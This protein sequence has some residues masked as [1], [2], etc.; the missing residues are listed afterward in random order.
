[1]I[2][3]FLLRLLSIQ[4]AH[5]GD[6]IPYPGLLAYRVNG[7]EGFWQLTVG[8]QLFGKCNVFLVDMADFPA[9]NEVYARFF[10]GPNPPAR[11][12]VAVAALPRGARVEIDCVA[13]VP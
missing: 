12:T 13:L 4:R 7:H 10:S 2:L 5:P 3:P 9:L 1:M 6:I 11:A 8:F